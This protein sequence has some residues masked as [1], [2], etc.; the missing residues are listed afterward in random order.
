[1]G[2][3]VSPNLCD[4]MNKRVKFGIYIDDFKSWD[5]QDFSAILERTFVVYFKVAAY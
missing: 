4:Q 3:C 2:N 1:M 5:F